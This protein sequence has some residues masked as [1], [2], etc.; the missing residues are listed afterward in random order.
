MSQYLI[1][2]QIIGLIVGFFAIIVIGTQ[3]ESYNQKILMLCVIGVELNMFGY[4]LELTAGS[5]ESI[6]IS[7]KIS[8]IGKVY[9]VF[10]FF[11]FALN[12]FKI[13]RPKWL[14]YLSFLIQ[15]GVLILVLT[16]E[17]H[18]LFYTSTALK[19][20]NGL[21]Y[22]V[23]GK[24]IIYVFYIL[25]VLV[26]MM[27]LTLL[28][29]RSLLNKK[30]R[31]TEKKRVFFLGLAGLFPFLLLMCYLSGFTKYYDGSS[32]GMLISCLLLIAS[33]IQY[34]LFDTI[35]I[36]KDTI[37]ANTKEGLIVINEDYQLLY[38]NQ[39]AK[40]IFP[41]IENISFNHTIQR[42]ESLI[43]NNVHHIEQNHYYYEVR[44]T[45][46]WDK[47]ILKG[48]LIWI[49]DITSLHKHNEELKQLKQKAEEAN[50]SKSMFLANMSHEIRTPMNAI[51]GM[52]EILLKSK[53]N[54]DTKEGI[55]CIRSAGKTL[56][57]IINDVL[58]LSKI[59]S[60]K[61]E[62]IPTQYE[63]GSV[64][65][66]IYNMISIKLSKSSV[67][68]S[69]DIKGNVPSV[70]KGDE[71]RIRQILINLLN[72]A[73]KFTDKGTITLEVSFKEENSRLSFRVIDTGKGIRKK[74]L[75]KL[76]ISF[77]RI[78]AVSNRN[79]EGTGLGLSICK[80]LVEQMGGD[81]SVES[82]YGK[83]STF[84]FAITQ[85]VL[86]HTPIDNL[87]ANT[88]Q[89]T[90]SQKN[91]LFQQSFYAPDVNI[92]IV[93]DNEINLKVAG[94][95]LSQYDMDIDVAT[96]GAM[97]L[98]M[99]KKKTYDIIFMDHMMPGMDG[100]ETLQW[101]RRNE[102]GINYKTPIAA[103][104]AN[105]VNGMKHKFIEAGFDDYISKPIE[106]KKVEKVLKNLLPSE[107]IK[108]INKK[109]PKQTSTRSEI[110]QLDSLSP[111]MVIDGVD[112][113]KGMKRLGNNK[114][115][116]ENLLKKVLEA[117]EDKILLL[118]KYALSEQWIQYIAEVRILKG[119]A[120]NIGAVSLEKMAYEHEFYGSKN[121][122]LFIETNVIRLLSEYSR[123]TENIQAYFSKQN[124]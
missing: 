92:L 51:L 46:I 41:E 40:N 16:A 75:D 94:S 52:T 62:I 99:T 64:L 31:K 90:L 112:T 70:L 21:S 10:F 98:S 2:L 37:M 66:D 86:D 85:E 101:I 109:S 71:I 34:E 84:S 95:M 78:D 113:K 12:Y 33:V 106:M 4:L 89:Q 47:S 67:S 35:E 30:V 49:L 1:I 119:I 122:Y 82:E 27:I 45:E 100:V 7:I 105:A 8:Y 5:I 24:G 32:I 118:E 117:A 11:H 61:M 36:A 96:S 65:N 81:I 57:S 23:L 68:L 58:D 59:E 72:N 43:E 42:I 13:K 48:Y 55:Y 108:P 69:I 124:N 123:I 22:I 116:Y 74:D 25:L 9:L 120:A 79:I 60:G 6:L 80:K 93:D 77:Q 50:Q 103:F 76:F 104:T 102:K 20:E 39:V 114:I 111:P 83:G 87:F 107:K 15:T 56:L 63:I 19:E 18:S 91:D 121:D 26:F 97:A 3:K 115:I 54:S 14:T 38:A 110:F 88:G 53:I 73:A 17:Y 28:C 29:L 44:C